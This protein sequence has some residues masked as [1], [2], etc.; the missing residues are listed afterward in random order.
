MTLVLGERR[1]KRS[2]V[3]EMTNQRQVRERERER[4]RERK[5]ERERERER[6]RPEHPALAPGPL[7]IED[8]WGRGDLGVESP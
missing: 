1:T 3:G 7:G 5:R 2:V 8:Q 4:E 6:W